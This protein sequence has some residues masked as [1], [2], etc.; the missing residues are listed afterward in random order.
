MIP[1]P[2]D[3]VRAT[4]VAHA[5]A[6]LASERDAKLLS[7]G[8]SL[9]PLMKLRLASTPLLIDI[10]RLPEL[11]GIEIHSDHIAIGA[12]TSHAKLGDHSQLAEL[13]PLFRMAA[14]VIADPTVRN[15]GTIGGS[16]VYADPSA[17]WPAV[18]LALDARMEITSADGTRQVP[19]DEFFVGFMTSAVQ[20]DELLTRILIP[21]PGP[22]RV[23]YRKFRHPSSGYAVAAAAV[24]LRYGGSICTGG[25]IGVTGVAETAFRA[26]AAEIEL[27]HGFTGSAEEIARLVELAFGGTTP[28]EDGFADGAYRIQLAKVMLSRALAD[29]VRQS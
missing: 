18:M 26:R 2:V 10:G 24:A 19:A 12:A 22:D 28:L 13:S 21:L 5:L 9:L 15:R 20:Q 16:L 7:G 29:A 6:M 17:D 8:H 1:Y 23:A 25:M 27:G 4:S 11:H 14:S 3:Y